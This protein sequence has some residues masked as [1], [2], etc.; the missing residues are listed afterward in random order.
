MQVM[1]PLRS[2]LEHAKDKTHKMLRAKALECISLVGMAVGKDLFREDAH[3][4]M[5]FMQAMQVCC[6]PPGTHLRVS[7]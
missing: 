4:V 5:R 6:N 1:P 3:A 2:V 7:S